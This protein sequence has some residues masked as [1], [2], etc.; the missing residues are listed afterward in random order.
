MK[1]K[2]HEMLKAEHPGKLKSSLACWEK[3]YDFKS[4]NHESNHKK[5]DDTSK[6][7]IKNQNED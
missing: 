3:D 6:L 7:K 5:Y 2:K 4:H 1:S